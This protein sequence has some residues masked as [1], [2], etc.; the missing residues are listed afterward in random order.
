VRWLANA[1]ARTS[2][3]AKLAGFA[4]VSVLGYIGYLRLRNRG[5]AKEAEDLRRQNTIARS[6]VRVAYLEGMKERNRERLEA[7]PGEVAR[8]DDQILAEKKAAEEA[9]A[10]VAGLDDDG[11][12]ARFRDLGF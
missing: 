2:L 4:V 5:L 3:W 7:I 11:V 1:W 8:L 10:R 6:G 12:A 9:R